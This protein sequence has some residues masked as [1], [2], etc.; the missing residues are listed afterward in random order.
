MKNYDIERHVT[1]ESQFVDDVITPEGM[2]HAY[3]FYSE[4]AQDRKSVV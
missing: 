3:V 4:K 2:L 1:G